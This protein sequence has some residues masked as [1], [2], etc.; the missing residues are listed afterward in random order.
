T[1]YF[2][3]RTTEW[4]GG[5]DLTR[6][7]GVSNITF[8]GF[9]NSVRILR[10][11]GKYITNSY[12]PA[13]PEN[14]NTNNFVSGSIRYSL[15]YVKD[16]ILPLSGV[17]FK[18]I[19]T[20]TQNLSDADKSFARFGSDVQFYIPVLPKISF[21]ISA[22]AATVTSSPKFYQY[23]SI[24]GGANLR[25]YTLNRFHGKTTFYN[26]NELRFITNINNYYLRG[27][28][29]LV[30]FFDNGRVWMP[31]EISNKF[32]TSYGGGILIAPF[33]IMYFDI[34]YGVGKETTLIQIR[35]TLTL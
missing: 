6:K 31:G 11:G 1:N 19:A 28:G 24:G 29:G 27:K 32:H 14:I 25:G 18:V 4:L 20:Y 30:A 21:A 35:G 2:R 10:D 13:H 5:I 16:S 17:I 33:N 9:F 8:S 23:P 3:L 34:T 12:L 26:S 22:G 7:L 15:F